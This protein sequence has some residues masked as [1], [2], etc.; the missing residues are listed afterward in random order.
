MLTKMTDNVLPGLCTEDH[1]SWRWIGPFKET[2][3]EVKQCTFDP[4]STRTRMYMIPDTKRYA[5][6][7]PVLQR[8]RDGS[9]GLTRSIVTVYWNRETSCKMEAS[10]SIPTTSSSRWLKVRKKY[11]TARLAAAIE[12]RCQEVMRRK[13][14]K[15]LS[16]NCYTGALG[17]AQ[18]IVHI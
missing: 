3:G 17:G 11:P 4:S 9:F 13:N 8:P 15:T 10:W 14:C 6:Y 5:L 2:Y 1:W 7:Q 18:T 16:E 12:R